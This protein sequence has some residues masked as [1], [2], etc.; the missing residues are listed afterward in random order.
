MKKKNLKLR[1]N[2]HDFNFG[3]EKL[4]LFHIYDD[5]DDDGE[6]RCGNE[7]V[8]LINFVR[9][10]LFWVLITA[11]LLLLLAILLLLLTSLLFTLDDDLFYVFMVS[12]KEASKLLFFVTYVRAS[13]AGQEAQTRHGVFFSLMT[14]FRSSFPDHH[15]IYQVSWWSSQKFRMFI[16]PAWNFNRAWISHLLRGLQWNEIQ[17]W[18]MRWQIRRRKMSALFSQGMNEKFQFYLNF[19]YQKSSTSS[20]LSCNYCCYWWWWSM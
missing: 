14:S 11:E 16:E 4:F 5:D 2:Q 13:R 19:H 3:F 10:F 8:K 1:R 18:S 17:S 9:I 6:V 12:T 20:Q 7:E 15:Q